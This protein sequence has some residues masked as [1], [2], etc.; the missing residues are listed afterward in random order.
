MTSGNLDKILV[1]SFRSA[2]RVFRDFESSKWERVNASV[3]GQI[4]QD[5]IWWGCPSVKLHYR[6][7][8]DGHWI[9]GLDEIPFLWLSEART[10][11]KSFPHN[12]P[13]IIRVNSENPQETHFF[14]RDQ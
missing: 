4:V 14:E 3:T 6:F 13:K 12:I 2:L 5:P 10:Y 1:C 7:Y 8:A 9:K 11:A